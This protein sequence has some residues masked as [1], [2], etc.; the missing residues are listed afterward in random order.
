MGHVTTTKRFQVS[1]DDMWARIGDPGALAAW[2]PAVDSTEVIDGGRTRVNHVGADKVVEPIMERGE[3]HY[4][5]RMSETH[6][7]FRDFESTLRVRDDEPDGCVVEWEATVA[8]AS[9]TEA[10]AEELVRGF[11]EA[12]LDALADESGG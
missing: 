5:F 9:V 11:F 7:P 8:P 4:S 3:K 2:H 10:E 12:G 6:L 1:A